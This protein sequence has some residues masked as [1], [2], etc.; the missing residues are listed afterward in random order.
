MP[1]STM[2]STANLNGKI[3][4]MYKLVTA[5]G[6]RFPKIVVPYLNGLPKV[7]PPYQTLDSDD[8]VY[9]YLCIPYT[10]IDTCGGSFYM[11]ESTIQS[12]SNMIA[13]YDGSTQAKSWAF[14]PLDICK[15]IQDN[16]HST[17]NMQNVSYKNGVK[18]S[19]VDLGDYVCIQHSGS[20]NYVMICVA[21]S[22]SVTPADGYGMPPVINHAS[23]SD[24]N[25]IDFRYKVANTAT[26][27]PSQLVNLLSSPITMPDFNI[28]GHDAYINGTTYAILRGYTAFQ[29]TSDMGN[30][31]YIEIPRLHSA[32]YI[33]DGR[34]RG[35]VNLRDVYFSIVQLYSTYG[36]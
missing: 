33:E 12:T 35:T 36:T 13:T 19:N 32:H 31:L 22:V 10:S 5:S 7:C 20:K 24:P 29:W 4:V 23:S 15:T 11:S 25:I 26:Y 30:Y 9:N 8:W 28:N 27:T 6:T 21:Y 3:P 14:R 2:A 34:S 16:G 17:G 1:L 18:N